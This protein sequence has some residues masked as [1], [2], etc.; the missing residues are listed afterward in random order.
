VH[1]PLEGGDELLAVAHQ[2]SLRHRPGVETEL[3][4]PP[5]VGDFP[6]A[7]RDRDDRARSSGE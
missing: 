2:A 6:E 7:G 3:R 4:G 1:A 5:L